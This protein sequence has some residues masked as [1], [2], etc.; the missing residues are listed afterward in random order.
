MLGRGLA[1]CDEMKCVRAL[2]GLQWHSVMPDCRRFKVAGV[3]QT[4]LKVC[5]GGKQFKHLQKL[6][7]SLVSKFPT[8]PGMHGLNSQIFTFHFAF[9]FFFFLS[10][11]KCCR[12]RRV[13]FCDIQL[14]ASFSIQL[15]VVDFQTST[16]IRFFMNSPLTIPQGNLGCLLISMWSG[17]VLESFQN[18][19]HLNDS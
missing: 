15:T 3:A 6:P 18:S 12:W 1:V 5:G 2:F 13:A 16:L 14:Y 17:T 19:S 7:T 10:V 9:F 11:R 4:Q 8:D